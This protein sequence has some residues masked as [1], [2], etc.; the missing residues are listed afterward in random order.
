MIDILLVLLNMMISTGIQEIDQETGTAIVI[1][2]GTVVVIE[3]V[4]TTVGTNDYQ[5]DIA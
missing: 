4:T 3:T 2:I 5:V 1:M